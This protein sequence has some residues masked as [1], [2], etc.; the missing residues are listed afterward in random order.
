M[1]VTE[2]E[3]CKFHSKKGASYTVRSVQVTELEGCKL[4]S[5]KCA[6][7][8]VRKVQ[9]TS[10]SKKRLQDVGSHEKV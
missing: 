8:R 1:Q 9:V 3:G 2:L 6:S 4:H 10:N 5:K 7:Y